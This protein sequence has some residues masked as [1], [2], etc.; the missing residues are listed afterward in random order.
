MT[1]TTDDVTNESTL[2]IRGIVTG[3]RDTGSAYDPDNSGSWFLDFTYNDFVV[4]G[5]PG[6]EHLPVQVTNSSSENKGIIAPLFDL[7]LTAVN[8]TEQNSLSN[9][10]SLG[11]VI[12]L[13]DKSNS[14]YTFLYGDPNDPGRCGTHPACDGRVEG[15][16]WVDHSINYNE[17][18]KNHIAASDFFFTGTA[19]V[20]PVPA[21]LP[22]MATAMIGFGVVGAMR[23]RRK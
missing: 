4:P 11:L 2:N 22:L 20:V 1:L 21:A 9:L 5:A 7:D 10:S 19:A 14:Q 18:T 3:G 23:R 8:E 6:D 15:H 17:A 16:G 13:V 12:N